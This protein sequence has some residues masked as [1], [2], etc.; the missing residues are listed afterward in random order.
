MKP[1]KPDNV[2]LE[3]WNAVDDLLLETY[4]IDCVDAG[5]EMHHIIAAQDDGQTPIEYVEWFGEKR[6]LVKYGLLK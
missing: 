5:I 6:G 1:T 3:Y 2:F 4:C